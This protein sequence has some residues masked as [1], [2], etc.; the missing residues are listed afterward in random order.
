[1]LSWTPHM[2]C[3]IS[4]WNLESCNHHHLSIFIYDWL[5]F[6]PWIVS[7]L[8]WNK[9]TLIP[10][11]NFILVSEYFRSGAEY[12]NCLIKVHPNVVLI[13]YHHYTG[14]IGQAHFPIWIGYIQKPVV[15]W[16][17]DK[18]KLIILPDNLQ[19]IW[20][21]L[22]IIPEHLEF[23]I[24]LQFVTNIDNFYKKM[25]LPPTGTPLTHNILEWY[26]F[27]TKI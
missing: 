1:M 2:G 18:G 13:M 20:C 4:T 5:D 16:S 23:S 11:A 17:Y 6:A 15:S 9:T 26:G 12:P 19:R 7:I 8:W 10:L 24:V 14:L 25:F 21:I 27:F 22:S 3:H